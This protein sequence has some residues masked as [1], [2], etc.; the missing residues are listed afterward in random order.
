M[1]GRVFWWSC[2]CLRAMVQFAGKQAFMWWP[3]YQ[4]AADDNLAE[5]ILKRIMNSLMA[6][7]RGT[8]QGERHTASL[9]INTLAAAFSMWA[10]LTCC[11]AIHRQ[12]DTIGGSHALMR[13]VKWPCSDHRENPSSSS[14]WQDSCKFW[15]GKIAPDTCKLPSGL[16][17]TSTKHK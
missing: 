2:H 10:A 16:V 9:I 3:L 1:H 7:T 8:M 4:R 11:L 14:L 5:S 6:I 13:S 12:G 15:L 17:V